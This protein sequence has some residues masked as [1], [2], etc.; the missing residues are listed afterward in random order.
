MLFGNGT[1]RADPLDL[2]MLPLPHEPLRIRLV[3]RGHPKDAQLDCD[4]G[5][6][7]AMESM[8]KAIC[9]VMSS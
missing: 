9:P 2:D 1:V 5:S 3:P 8:L 4:R 6:P 7:K